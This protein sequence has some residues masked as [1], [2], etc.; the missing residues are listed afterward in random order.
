MKKANLTKILNFMRS[1]TEMEVRMEMSRKNKNYLSIEKCDILRF[2]TALKDNIKDCLCVALEDNHMERENIL[3][4]PLELKKKVALPKDFHI[5]NHSNEELKNLFRPRPDLV[6]IISTNRIY[7]TKEKKLEHHGKLEELYTNEI[8]KR[9]CSILKKRLELEKER[10][11]AIL[12]K[13]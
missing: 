6:T 11:N 1:H 2:A 5:D 7:R 9:F 3:I 4:C 13:Q 12:N 10:L 8:Y